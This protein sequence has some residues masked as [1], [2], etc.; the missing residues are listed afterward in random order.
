MRFPKIVSIMLLEGKLLKYCYT[1][2]KDF[3]F[4][5]LTYSQPKY[6]RKYIFSSKKAIA[7]KYLITFQLL[8]DKLWILKNFHNET[9]GNLFDLISV[10]R[11]M[12]LEKQVD[13]KTVV[14]VLHQRT[15]SRASHLINQAL[16]RNVI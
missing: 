11:I 12:T 4:S 15:A 1:D 2:R 8:A 14:P 16:L 3:T 7:L 9:S 5:T 10:C 6:K 13:G